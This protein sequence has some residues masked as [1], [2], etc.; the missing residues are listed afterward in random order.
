MR[1]QDIQNGG[2]SMPLANRRNPAV[3]LICQRPGCGTIFHPFRGRES[4]PNVQKY[5]GHQCAIEA[6]IFARTGVWPERTPASTPTVRPVRPRQLTSED[7]ALLSFPPLGEVARAA[8]QE[9]G[10]HRA[11]QA[12]KTLQIEQ[13]RGDGRTIILAGQGS[14]LGVE[15]GSL[16]VHQARTHG[17]P[18][19]AKERLYPGVHGVSRIYWLGRGLQP[20]GTL[21]LAAL[22]FCRREGIAL[23][24]LDGAGEPLMNVAPEAPIE[25]A[26]R[27]RQY[28]LDDGERVRIARSILTRKLE[29]QRRTILQHPELPDQ[30]RALDALDMALGWLQLP[31]ATPY[32]STPDGL[33][34]YEARCAR[35]YWAAWVGLPLRWDRKMLRRIPPHWLHARERTSPLAGNRNARHAVDPCNAIVNYA[36]GVLESQTRQALTTTGFD[37]PCGFLHSDKAGRDSLVFDM[38]ECE[39][40]AVDSL[41]LDFIGKTTVFRAGD[42]SRQPDGSV[43]LHPQLARAVVAACRLPQ[44]RMDGHARWLRSRLRNGAT[45][46]H[47]QAQESATVACSVA[48]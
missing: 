38:M 23:A 21:T 15:D 11:A 8:W 31:E 30:T 20:C 27:R 5:C 35:A 41:V 12:D 9:V 39:R 10:E 33:L 18:A 44:E 43:R 6:G 1:P 46:E 47:S 40:G 4:G 42:F 7:E 14:Y 24:L 36:Y 25:T 32:L 37:L 26:L 48:L 17:V 2:F 16:I 3:T 29:G 45:Q 28:T 22:A 13:T 19:P 34:V